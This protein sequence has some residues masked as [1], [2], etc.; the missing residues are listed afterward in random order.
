MGGRSAAAVMFHIPSRLMGVSPNQY[1]ALMACLDV[2]GE[3]AIS[4]SCGR[5]CT[6]VWIGASGGGGV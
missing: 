1:L 6:G 5:K 2:G 3:A 4:V